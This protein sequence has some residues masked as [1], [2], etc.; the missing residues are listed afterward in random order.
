VHAVDRDC[1][2][3]HPCLLWYVCYC[4]LKLISSIT[5]LVTQRLTSSNTPLSSQSASS[6]TLATS[7]SSPVPPSV[8]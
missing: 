1:L 5:E 3:R 4:P 7:Q 2:S 6:V 8:Q